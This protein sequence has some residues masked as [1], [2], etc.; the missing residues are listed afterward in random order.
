[1]LLGV[2]KGVAN[3]NINLT[4]PPGWKYSTGFVSA[5]MIS[6]QLPA[7]GPDTAVMMCGPPPMIKFACLPN[8]EK[9]GY[10]ESSLMVF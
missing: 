5:D 7:P 9:L 4:P 3:C 6:E 10:P 2:A 1:V 8:L